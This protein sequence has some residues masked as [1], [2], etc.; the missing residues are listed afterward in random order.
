[1][2]KYKRHKTE[3]ELDNSGIFTLV[4]V[5]NLPSWRAAEWWLCDDCKI[6]FQFEDEILYDEKGDKFRCPNSKRIFGTPCMKQIANGSPEY[7]Q[8]KCIIE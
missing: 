7:F 5:K 6:I 4:K 3:K 2:L 1:M 8:E